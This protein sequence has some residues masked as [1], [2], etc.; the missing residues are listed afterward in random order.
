LATVH[1]PLMA[2]WNRLNIALSLFSPLIDAPDASWSGL[3]FCPESPC[4]A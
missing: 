3:T 2:I 1:L 4:A